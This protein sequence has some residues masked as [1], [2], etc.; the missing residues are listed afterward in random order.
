[1]G[2]KFQK[3]YGGGTP[4]FRI[5]MRNYI[6]GGAQFSDNYGKYVPVH[7]KNKIQIQRLLTYSNKINITSIDIATNYSGAIERLSK[8][9]LISNFQAST[10][11]Q[12]SV[13]QEKFIY[14][15]LNDD[16]MMLKLNNYNTIFIH[17]W[18]ELS[19][20]EKKKSSNF[21]RV[22]I[23][24][25]IAI[26]PGISVYKA[27]ELNN[28]EFN[29]GVVQAPLNFY[30]TEFINSDHALELNNSGIKFQARS[31]FHQGVLLNINQKLLSKYRD[32]MIFYNYCKINK[33]SHLEACLNVFDSQSLFTELVI[34]VNNLRQ[35]KQIVK[36]PIIHRDINAFAGNYDFDEN[37]TDPRNWSLL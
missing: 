7:K 2:G 21:L 10:K 12:Y 23:E 4:N 31:L 33:I 26:Q 29:Q 9:K 14:D 24:D 37:F 8:C 19:S 15:S 32:L 20:Q 1:M 25:G 6:L 28:F 5:S 16:L 13:S 36:V 30:N 27:S 35:L 22:L 18:S 11:I 34:G 17:N 3:I